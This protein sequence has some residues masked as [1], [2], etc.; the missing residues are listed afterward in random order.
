MGTTL[1]FDEDGDTLIT[2]Y[3]GDFFEY[4]DPITDK[5]A[6]LIEMQLKIA[7]Q[8]R[9]NA[10]QIYDESFTLSITLNVIAVIIMVASGL[11][12]GRTIS[13]P[14]NELRKLIEK[15]DQDKDLTVKVSIDQTDEIGRVARSFQHMMDQ[16]H[17]I[18]ED[19]SGTS[20]QLQTYATTLSNTTEQTRKDVAIQT[21][22]TDHEHRS[23]R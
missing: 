5:V 21:H 22:E 19:V 9:Q 16:F 6:T 14:L 18:I 1:Q 3:N 13:G 11:W 8:E 15:A 23:Q 2:D 20:T 12:V 10:Q 4:L 7:Q 17:D